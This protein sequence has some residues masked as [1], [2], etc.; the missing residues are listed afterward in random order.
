MWNDSK[1]TKHEV[2][3]GHFPQFPEINLGLK[4]TFSLQKGTSNT[5]MPISETNSLLRIWWWFLPFEQE[6]K[7][8]Y[9]L[10][11]QES[12]SCISHNFCPSQLFDCP[13]LP[14]CPT[15]SF[16]T[17]RLSNTVSVSAFLQSVSPTLSSSRL[18]YCLS[19]RH[20]VLLIFPT[21]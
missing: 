16:R 12:S 6:L 4:S 8:S 5:N 9:N 7:A 2:G 13:F 10:I 11:N 1:T 18:S 17:I 14:H 19:L 3:Q 21:V 15:L 20:S